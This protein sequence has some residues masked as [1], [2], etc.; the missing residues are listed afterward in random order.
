MSQPHCVRNPLSQPMMNN[1]LLPPPPP[2]TQHMTFFPRPPQG[3]SLMPGPSTFVTSFPMP[4]LLIPSLP[5]PTF[6]IP[7][8]FPVLSVPMGCDDIESSLRHNLH[9]I[10]GLMT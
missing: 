7:T 9:A 6:P 3:D 10:V 8:T 1:I 5:V 2:L 4:S